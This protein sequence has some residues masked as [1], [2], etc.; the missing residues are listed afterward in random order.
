MLTNIF[1]KS[2]KDSEKVV[3]QQSKYSHS[4]TLLSKQENGI[5]TYTSVSFTLR[6]PSTVFIKT[7]CG[8]SWKSMAFLKNLSESWKRMAFLKNLTESWKRMAF[9]KNLS[10]SRSA[11]ILTTNAK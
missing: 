3:V 10:E 9:L 4:G 5:L 6:K 1:K 8:K 2:R 7:H 11:C